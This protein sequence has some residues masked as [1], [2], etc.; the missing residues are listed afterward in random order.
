ME[1]ITQ[2]GE[3]FHLRTSCSRDC[4]GDRCAAFGP[5]PEYHGRIRRPHPDYE[6]RPIIFNEYMNC[7][8]GDPTTEKVETFIG[9]AAEAGAEYFCID[10]GWF[11]DDD[12]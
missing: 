2:A 3:V 8:M 9:P 7:L 1:Q 10:C 11:Y 12:G 4:K 5:I 6:Q